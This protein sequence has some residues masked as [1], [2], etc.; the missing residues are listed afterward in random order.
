MAEIPDTWACI[1][2]ETLPFGTLLAIGAGLAAT[3]GS[4]V[5]NWHQVL[6]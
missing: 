1:R 5:L 4:R 3:A 2:L 6:V